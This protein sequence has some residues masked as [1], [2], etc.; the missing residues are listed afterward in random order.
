MVLD[1]AKKGK[2]EAEVSISWIMPCWS[3]LLSIARDEYKLS[4]I[5]DFNVFWVD[6]KRC[7]YSQTIRDGLGRWEQK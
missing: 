3:Y 1:A 4:L 6:Q 7:R 2:L 5:F